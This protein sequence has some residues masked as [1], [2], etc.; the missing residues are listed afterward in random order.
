VPPHTHALPTLPH[1]ERYTY[2]KTYQ[3]MSMPRSNS[4]VSRWMSNNGSD[5]RSLRKLPRTER[6]SWCPRQGFEFRSGFR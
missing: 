3:D 6:V 4:L 1:S 5:S 2:T